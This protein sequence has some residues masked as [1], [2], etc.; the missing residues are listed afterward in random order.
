MVCFVFGATAFRVAG[1]ILGALGG[2][3]LWHLS[4]LPPGAGTAVAPKLALAGAAVMCGVTGL[5]LPRLG[6]VIG[7]GGAGLAAGLGL[8]LGAGLEPGLGM[9]LGAGLGAFAMFVLSPTMP[10]LL[11][12][13]AGAMLVSAA[14][15]AMTGARRE[16]PEVLRVPIVWLAVMFALWALGY[17]LEHGRQLRR[18]ARAKEQEAAD[19]A[20]KKR[21]REEAL[22]R[23]YERYMK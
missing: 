12:P 9:G 16:G 15:F 3:L 11:P 14:G 10:L 23:G 5:L 17:A 7:G 13:L 6:G 22:A 4:P 19:A 18:E 8:A 20:E 21:R 1:L 2:A